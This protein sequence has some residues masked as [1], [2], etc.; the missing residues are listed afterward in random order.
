MSTAL[1]QIHADPRGS[2]DESKAET[3]L[4]TID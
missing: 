2:I 4:D 3:A 1:S